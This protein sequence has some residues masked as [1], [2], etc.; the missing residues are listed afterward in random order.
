[1]CHLI[2]PHLTPSLT[3]SLQ[4]HCPFSITC[5]KKLG[6]FLE[7]VIIQV[8][9]EQVT[10]V[11]L[12]LKPQNLHHNPFLCFTKKKIANIDMA[13]PSLVTLEL[14]MRSLFSLLSIINYICNF[15]LTPTDSNIF[16]TSV[17]SY[18]QCIALTSS[19]LVTNRFSPLR[20]L[21]FVATG[22]PWKSTL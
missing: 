4:P 21:R 18:T 13:H 1:L 16:F 19:Y 10:K 20:M 6:M 11:I 3:F 22:A 5:H 8:L 17:V 2:S 9:S 7:Q 12:G 15:M 14:L